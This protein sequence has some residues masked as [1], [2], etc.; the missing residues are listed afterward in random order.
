MLLCQKKLTGKNW[1]NDR[2]LNQQDL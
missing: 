1:E 2:W